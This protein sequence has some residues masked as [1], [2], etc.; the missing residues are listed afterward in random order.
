MVL[1]FSAVNNLPVLFTPLPNQSFQ[2]ASQLLWLF[3]LSCHYV[4][5]D[6]FQGHYKNCTNG[7]RDFRATSSISFLLQTLFCLDFQSHIDLPM[8][9][10]YSALVYCLQSALQETVHECDCCGVHTFSW[11]DFGPGYTSFYKALSSVCTFH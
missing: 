8:R 10:D 3:H 11:F 5:V 4:F 9:T 1:L 6:T 2:E 7:S